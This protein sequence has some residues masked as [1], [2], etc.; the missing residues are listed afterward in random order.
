MRR[1]RASVY[2]RPGPE[3]LTRVCF[4]SWQ[5]L[6]NFLARRPWVL[7]IIT[8]LTTVMTVLAANTLSLVWPLPVVS[9]AFILNSRNIRK[10]SLR[11]DTSRLPRITSVGTLLIILLLVGA[12][13]SGFEEKVRHLRLAHLLLFLSSRTRPPLRRVVSYGMAANIGGVLHKL[14]GWP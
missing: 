1:G 6:D 2:E 9:I 7:G 13:V 12:G 10:A 4:G 11:V 8:V 3:S 5:D 14:T